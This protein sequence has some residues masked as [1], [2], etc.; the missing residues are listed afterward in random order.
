MFEYS[1]ANGFSTM[2][3]IYAGLSILILLQPI[4]AMIREKQLRNQK[5]STSNPKQ[6]MEL[7]GLDVG[8][9]VL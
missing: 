3:Y 5:T 4:D 9:T 8:E 7:D 1:Q 6:A 2:N